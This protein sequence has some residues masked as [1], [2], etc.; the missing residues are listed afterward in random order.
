M[1]DNK[2]VLVI[3]DE[4]SMRKALVR[5]LVRQEFTALEAANGKEGLEMALRERPDMILLDIIMPVMDGLTMLGKLREQGEWG[6]GVPVIILTNLSADSEKIISGV[7]KHEPAF[8]MVKV[9]WQ[10]HDVVDRVR[11]RL[12]SK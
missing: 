10:P 7:A 4:E 6:K 5:E 12:S 8:Y 11:E 1:S 3:E 2:K 9:N